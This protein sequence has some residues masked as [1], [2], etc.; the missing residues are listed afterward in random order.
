VP[1]AAPEPV[2][3]EPV[4]ERARL[5]HTAPVVPEPVEPE[6]VVVE[7]V[8]PVAS[9]PAPAP[10]PEPVV[11][12]PS[13]PAPEPEP[14]VVE[15]EPV[16]PAKRRPKPATPTALT[17]EAEYLARIAAA[18]EL[19]ARL[20]AART[21]PSAPSPA[22]GVSPLLDAQRRIAVVLAAADDPLTAS[23]LA[24]KHLTPAQ[25]VV[26]DAALSDGVAQGAFVA[27]GG[28]LGRGARYVLRDPAPLGLDWDAITTAVATIH[29]GRAARRAG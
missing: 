17:L 9:T 11:V 25:R 8:S 2:A 12:E 21:A 26:R 5:T 10:E 7:P 23:E 19:H 20:A 18:T 28:I 29:A 3:P 16:T 22:I 14:V 6:P 1:V 13:A 27:V 4:R 15:P 24:A